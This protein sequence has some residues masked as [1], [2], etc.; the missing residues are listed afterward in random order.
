MKRNILLVFGVFLIF[1][2]LLLLKNRDV[3]DDDLIDLVPISVKKQKTKMILINL[4]KRKDRLHSVI[5]SF[6][7]SDFKHRV[8]LYR[9]PAVNGREKINSITPLLSKEASREYNFYLNTGHRT[10]HHSLTEGGMG[11][12][13]SHINAWKHVKKFGTPCIIAEDDIDIP[14]DACKNM[15]EIISL[16]KTIPKKKPYVILF[17]SICNSFSWDG[18]ECVHVRDGVYN[19]KQFWSM[20]FYYLTPEVARLLLKNVFPIEY[21][22]DHLLS[23]LNQKGLI[24]VYYVKDIVGMA[25]VD[26]DIQAPV[27]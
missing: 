17:H 14:Y 4:D 3:D 5:S 20:A 11:C 26:T 15:N 18:L 12:Y 1:I 2:V 9:L 19:A 21:Q 23:M 13:M 22:V 27:S 7:E 6:N 16:V 8:D 10:G 25:I 24:D